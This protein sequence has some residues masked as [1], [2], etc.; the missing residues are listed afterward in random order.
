V[1][2]V[3]YSTQGDP[4]ISS[5]ADKVIRAWSKGGEMLMEIEGHDAQVVLLCWSKDDAHIFSTSLDNTICKWRLID[6]KE[7]VVFWGHNSAII[8]LFLSTNECHLV[9]TSLD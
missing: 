8:S 9:S 5:R 4:F 3:R 7:L 2:A 1:H 6:G